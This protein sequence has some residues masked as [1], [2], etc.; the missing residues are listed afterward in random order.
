MSYEL[1]LIAGAPDTSAERSRQERIRHAAAAMP[2]STGVSLMATDTAVLGLVSTAPDGGCSGELQQQAGQIECIIGTSS[3]ALAAA[4]G[5]DGHLLGAE[6]GHVRVVVE[7]DGAV[8]VSTDGL[9]FVP[10]YWALAEESLLVSTHLASLVSLGL[11]ARVD[12]RG[13]CE[14]LAL[15][16]PLQQRTLLEGASAMPPGGRL[17]WAGGKLLDM[18]SRPLFVP[19]K[20]PSLTDREVVEA[21][22]TLWPQALADTMARS[23]G[24]RVLQGLSGGLDSRAI[25]TGL[26]AQGL[27]PLAYTYGSLRNRETRVATAIAQRL[28]LPHMVIP[29]HESSRLLRGTRSAALLDGAHSPTQMYEAWF[30]DHLRA[31]GDVIINGLAGGPLWGD[32]KAMGMLGREAVEA[33]I[34]GRYQRAAEHADRFV[35]ASPGAHPVP[36]CVRNGLH[37]S[38]TPWDFET[39]DD[40]AVFWKL[41]NRQVRWGNMLINALRREGLRIEAPF[42]DSRIVELCARL[43][44][45]QRRNGRLYLQVHREVLT[46]TAD[47]PRSDDGNSPRDLD[48]VYWSGDSSLGRQLLRLASQH[49]VSGTRR[50]AWRAADTVGPRLLHRA[51]LHRAAAVRT[52]RSSVFPADAWLRCPGSYRDRLV[53]ML[54]DGALGSGPL[55]SDALL[56]AAAALRAGRTTTSAALLGNVATAGIWLKDYSSRERSRPE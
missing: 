56:E 42:L 48:H 19:G 10:C 21:F 50:A 34:W 18:T 47:I 17:S 38:L 22:K 8:V 45:Q 1:V 2:G 46:A 53:G 44:P 14:Y 31:S 4:R 9:A 6:A 55:R 23:D 43:S 54:E 35:E 51:G 13:L 49:P 28:H 36:T 30:T 3:T 27:R 37:E 11:S 12:R 26:A 16:H 25:A 5:P 32:D 15:L 24:D 40:M 41:S 52:D 39:R 20:E 33:K 7:R 29:V